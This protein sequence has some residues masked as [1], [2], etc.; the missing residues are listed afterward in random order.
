MSTILRARRDTGN[1]RFFPSSANVAAHV[2]IG[3]RGRIT[4]NRAWSGLTGHKRDIALNYTIPLPLE[5]TS[6]AFRAG[7]ASLEL[8][9]IIARLTT[10]ETNS[11]S[12]G[13]LENQRR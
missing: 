13:S 8:A 9:Q 6:C 10:S 5:L 3:L 7:E 12:N 11:L 4:G 2:A 1:S